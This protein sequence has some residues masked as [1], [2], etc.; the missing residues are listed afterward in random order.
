M[1]NNVNPIRPHAHENNSNFAAHSAT[2]QSNSHA[3]DGFI[4]KPEG[5]APTIEFALYFAAHGE[6]FYRFRQNQKCLV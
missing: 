4:G 5:D 1:S 6:K 3:Q 2:G